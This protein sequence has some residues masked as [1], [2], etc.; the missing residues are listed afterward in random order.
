M[1]FNFK[2]SVFFGYFL[3]FILQETQGEEFPRL[4]LSV[5]EK[6][7]LHQ[8]LSSNKK[9]LPLQKGAQKN[10]LTLDGILYMS[11][12]HW[13]IWINGILITTEKKSSDFEVVDVQPDQ[14]TLIH[15]ASGQTVSLAPLQTIQVDM[16]EKMAKNKKTSLDE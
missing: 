13:S 16:K 7:A 1:S 3:S 15:C 9:P 4:M 14:V 11:S 5:S 12:S 10:V 2:I 6:E 8:A